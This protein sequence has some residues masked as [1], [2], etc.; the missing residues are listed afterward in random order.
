MSCW[1][2][3]IRPPAAPADAGADRAG[4]LRLRPGRRCGHHPRRQPDLER[5]GRRA[6]RRGQQRRR[7]RPGSLNI[8]AE[9][10]EFGY[11]PYTQP[12]GGLDQARL[13][14]GFANVNLRASDRITANHRGSLSV[15][16]TRGAYDSAGG[17]QYSGG[18]LNLFTPLLTG[19][20]LGQPD[21]G[22]RRDQPGHARRRA[23]RRDTRPGRGTG[24]DAGRLNIDGR[25]AL[26]SGKVA[27][28]ADRALVLTGQAQLDLAGRPVP[29]EELTKYSW[30][31]EAILESRHGDITQA[32]GSIIDLFARCTTAPAA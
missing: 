8:E 21:Q 20:R 25:I 4:H 27:L 6:G 9:R 7:H 31:G 28:R 1:T 29:F 22:R 3:W 13:T 18:T 12:A 15:Y 16:Q 2:R 23:G 19:N 17:W 30:G 32:A 10:I 26:P 14:L 11:G 24:L 5:R